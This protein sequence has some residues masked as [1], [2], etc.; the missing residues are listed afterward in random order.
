M[1]LAKRQS[2][3]KRRIKTMNLRRMPRPVPC[4][5]S[6]WGWGSHWK[7]PYHLT[8]GE[9]QSVRKKARHV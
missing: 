7:S 1:N 3:T 2:R 6:K 9:T 4:E 5:P 8:P